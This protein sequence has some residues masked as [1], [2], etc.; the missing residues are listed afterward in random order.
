MRVYAREG[1]KNTVGKTEKHANGNHL[2]YENI[3]FVRLARENYKPKKMWLNQNNTRSC[4]VICRLATT[5][6]TL[7]VCRISLFYFSVFFFALRSLSTQSILEI[8]LMIV[9][10]NHVRFGLFPLLCYSLFLMKIFTIVLSC[11]TDQDKSQLI[12]CRAGTACDNCNSLF[13]TFW[14]CKMQRLRGL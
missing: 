9:T 6:S 11:Y 7:I 13:C 1:I 10:N 5:K 3:F 12:D 8:M 2:R 14:L 4:S